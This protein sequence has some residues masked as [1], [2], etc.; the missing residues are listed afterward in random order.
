MFFAGFSAFGQS[1][2][3]PPLLC[4]EQ[5]AAAPRQTKRDVVPCERSM[6]NTQFIQPFA[7]AFKCD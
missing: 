1:I 3:L 2:V 7:A 4:S 6:L 5:R